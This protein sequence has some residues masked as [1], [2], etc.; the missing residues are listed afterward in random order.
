AQAQPAAAASGSLEVVQAG[1]P[2]RKTLTLTTTEP[3][4]IE[5]LEQTPIHSKLAAYVGQVLVD[6]GDTVQKDQA[7]IKLSAPE[8]DAELV[9]K[10][11]LVEQTRAELLQAE[12]GARAAEAAV[13]TAKSKVVQ[14]EAGTVRAQHDI[15]LWR[16]QYTRYGQLA[17]SGSVKRELV[18]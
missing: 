6:Y 2:V 3:A 8:L 15:D 4:H 9:Q 5:A 14:A 16:S 17:G 13:T 1:N 18:D 12:A 11:A 10:Q 7:L